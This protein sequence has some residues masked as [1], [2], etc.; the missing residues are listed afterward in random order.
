MARRTKA[1]A[2]QTRMLLLDAA[3][4]VFSE[5]GVAHSSLDDIAKA[6]SLTRGAIY[7]HFANKGELFEAMRSRIELPIDQLRADVV[8]K[9]D[10]IQALQ[11]FWSEALVRVAEDESVRRVLDIMFHKCEYVGELENLR[12]R[13][14]GMARTLIDL[15]T[16]AYAEAGRKGLLASSVDPQMAAIATHNFVAGTLSNW[17]LMP[18]CCDLKSSAGPLLSLFMR[19]LRA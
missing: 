11:D 15:M 2:E 1:E 19:G 10:P 13:Q 16:H 3:E 8:S 12:L 5:Y 4:K 6:A 18:D 14:I 9:D 7:W 17:L